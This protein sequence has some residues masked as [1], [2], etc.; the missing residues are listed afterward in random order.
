MRDIIYERTLT[1]LKML[2]YH[3]A[4]KGFSNNNFQAHLLKIY[5]SSNPASFLLTV[6]ESNNAHIG[7]C[8]RENQVQ[9]QAKS[10]KIQVT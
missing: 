6:P 9:S 8:V 7:V 2:R 5:I 10:L 1:E 3:V 4:L